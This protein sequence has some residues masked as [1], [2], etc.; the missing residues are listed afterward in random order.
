MATE[1]E[2]PWIALKPPVSDPMTYLTFIEHNLT[3]ESLPQLHQVLQDKELNQSIGW[4]LVQPLIPLVPESE[5][6]LLAIA[7]LGNPREV[8]LKVSEALRLLELDEISEDEDSDDEEAVKKDLGAL[9]LGGSSQAGAVR[10]LGLTAEPESSEADLP[11]PVLQF[12]VLLSMLSILHPR[13]KTKLP[14]RFLSTT[15][16]AVLAAYGKATRNHDDLT[17]DVVKF[18]NTLTG[19][20]RPHLPP[21]KSSMNILQ[22]NLGTAITDPEGQAEKPSEEEKDM[23]KRLLQSFLTHILEDYML[24]LP[25]V[26]DVP[27]MAWASRLQEKLNPQRTVPGKQSHVSRFEKDDRLKSRLTTVGSISALAKDLDLDSHEIFA[28][29]MDTSPE[30][31]GLESNEDDPPMSPKDIPLSK[32]GALFLLAARKAVETLYD[33][34]SDTP[35]ISIFPEHATVLQNF[36]GNA[37]QNTSGLEPEA[38]IDTVLFLGLIALENNDV[39]E[40]HS[41]D[42]FNHYLQNASLL[43]ANTPSP[44]LRYHAHFITSTVLRSHPHDLVRLSFIKDTLEHCPYEN[45]KASAVG[46]I[47]GETMEANPRNPSPTESDDGTS[48]FAT[49][50]ALQT[51]APFLFPNLS[52]NQLTQPTLGEG[53]AQFKANLSFYLASLNFLWLLLVAKHLHD[54]L[55]IQSLYQNGGIEGHFLDPVRQAASS[56]LQGLKDGGELWDGEQDVSGEADLGIV[57]DVLAR[58]EDVVKKLKW[59]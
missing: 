47:K 53:Y 15:L 32:S 57:N 6:C 52:N 18:V 19:T 17:Y 12:R 5:K 8:V 38:L 43:S 26:E 58:V 7:R 9:E 59:S 42:D 49:P 29:I 41:D 46:W 44:N 48:I 37:S 56:Y 13:I 4:D 21:R 31:T 39:G 45:L 54:P 34:T 14:S 28:T 22:T 16:Q 51:L 20:K 50:I 25:S 55:D 33:K 11:L 35:P 36:I 10:G 24:S 3:T 27:G 1:D 2:N 30:L 40:P 23:Q